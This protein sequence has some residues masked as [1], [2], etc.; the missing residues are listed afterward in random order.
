M[1]TERRRWLLSAALTLVLLVVIGFAAVHYQPHGSTLA[2][3]WPTSGIAVAFLA[4]SPGRGARSSW[5][6]WPF[7]VAASALW[8][9]RPVFVAIALGVANV[10]G[11]AV[12]I[13]VLARRYPGP[14]PPADPRG[15]VAAPR[16]P[17]SSAAPSTG[18]VIAAALSSAPRQAVLVQ[19]AV[20]VM[21]LTCRLGPAD[22]PAGHGRLRT[23]DRGRTRLSRRRS[24][25][26]RC[27]PSSTVFG[28]EQHLPVDFLPIPLL[29]WGAMRL[30][31]RL[32]TVELLVAGVVDLG[33]DQPGPRADRPRPGRGRSA[34]RDRQRAW[35][36]P[37][38]S[39]SR[40]WCCRSP[41]PRRQ[42]LVALDQALA[43]EERFRRSFSDSLIGM[44]L[45]RATPAGLVV[46]EANG[47]AAA[48]LGAE[49]EQLLGRP[50]GSGLHAE[51]PRGDAARLRRH[52]GGPLVRLG[53]RGAARQRVRRWVRLAASALE[54]PGGRADAERAAGRPDRGAAGAGGPRATSG[55][56]PRPSWTPPT[57]S[58]SCSTSTAA[59]CAST[60][61]PRSSAG[62]GP[63][64]CWVPGPGTSFGAELGDRLHAR[65]GARNPG[66]VPLPSGRG[67]RVGGAR[68]PAAHG[69]R[70]RAPTSTRPRPALHMVMTGIDVTDE[71]LAQRL[72]DQV[73][74][75]TTGT[76]IIGT[77]PDGIITFYNPGAER[78]LGWTAEEVVGKVTPGDL[79]RPGRDR[80]TAARSSG[81][82]P[83]SG[84]SS[85]AC[86]PE[87]PAG[88]AGLELRPQGR[89]ARSPCR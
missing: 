53:A 33:D 51:R 49:P 29:M 87:P 24:R 74:A 42:R 48:L 88:E 67:G 18:V 22:Q 20:S 27:S 82:T 80:A 1:R 70:G 34:A 55:T 16:S 31:V 44:L 17:R 25:C 40:S 59:S 7:A 79:P 45:L 21:A 72:V 9:G 73:L 23:A 63:R 30:P 71:R 5:P 84:C 8:A 78:L 6:R 43:G 54:R 52:P 10:A 62:C 85:R 61:P 76:S 46:D 19:T 15:P 57:P 32:V 66:P 86:E 39:A 65:L 69:R 37:T 36:R 4:R 12:V 83:A 77:D 14:G 68:R 81:S 2:A 38:S 41:S 11:A 75:A 35:C 28:P 13:A 58:S 56:S 26:S 89:R 3:W 50:W 60:R 47:V 64:T